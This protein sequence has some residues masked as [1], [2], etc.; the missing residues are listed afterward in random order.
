MQILA[1]IRNNAYL[2]NVNN[3]QLEPAATD[4]RHKIMKAFIDIT[5]KSHK[6]GQT[7]INDQVQNMNDCYA[8]F[9]LNMEDLKK[10]AKRKTTESVTI[11]VKE[12][13]NIIYQYTL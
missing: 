7:F 12:Q 6:G 3:K 8:W 11:Y 5:T 13:Y 4:K 2:C 9:D 10:I 1:H